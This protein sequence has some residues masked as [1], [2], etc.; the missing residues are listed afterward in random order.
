MGNWQKRYLGCNQ[1][2]GDEQA[3]Q[4]PALEP[5]ERRDWV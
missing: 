3:C 1:K 4:D 5:P 2:H